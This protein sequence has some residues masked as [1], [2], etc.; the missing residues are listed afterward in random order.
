VAYNDFAVSGG[1]DFKFVTKS[2]CSY[3][4]D[5]IKGYYD[6]VIVNGGV[7][8][9]SGK[10]LGKNVNNFCGLAGLATK[11]TAVVTANAAIADKMAT[12]CTKRQ[13]FRIQFQ[14]DNFEIPQMKFLKVN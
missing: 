6:C 12:L 9:K 8:S 7:S 1:D 2:C 10:L 4:D 14:S 11:T 3:G 13:P 5:G